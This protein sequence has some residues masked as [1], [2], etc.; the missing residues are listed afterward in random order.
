MKFNNI[1]L[2]RFIHKIKCSPDN[3]LDIQL[4][5]LILSAG[6]ENG[7]AIDN[8][9]KPLNIDIC[10]NNSR[11]DCN[12][13]IIDII[14]SLNEIYNNP[15]L[16]NEVAKLNKVNEKYQELY[17]KAKIIFCSY[18]NI[19]ESEFKNLDEEAI[20]K[21]E[22]SFNKNDLL[23]TLVPS[24][25]LFGESELITLSRNDQLNIIKMIMENNLSSNNKYAITTTSNVH[26]ELFNACINS[27]GCKDMI[28]NIRRSIENKENIPEKQFE[29]ANNKLSAIFVKSNVS[30]KN[31]NNK[32]TENQHY[33]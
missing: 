16:K 9:F 3:Y 22:E 2:L 31:G 25:D 19:N 14:P 7:I 20:K 27:K 15:N 18:A 32:E 30:P 23:K 28:R 17:K 26:E 6:N 33:Y 21:I 12:K 8:N 5:F 1:L 11:S 13:S 4:S 29:I 10:I 24:I